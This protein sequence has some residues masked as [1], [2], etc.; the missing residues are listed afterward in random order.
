[1]RRICQEQPEQ[2]TEKLYERFVFRATQRKKKK[3]KEKRSAKK[4]SINL[5][6]Y[7]SIIN[8]AIKTATIDLI[9]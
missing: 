9:K 8:H 6:D 5:Y 3:R 2:W 4:N 7:F 1:M